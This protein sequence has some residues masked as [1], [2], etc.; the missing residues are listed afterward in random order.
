[1]EVSALHIL[2]YFSYLFITVVYAWRTI[3]YARMPMHLRWDLYPIPREADRKYGGSYFE[4][5]EW[6]KKR[7]RKGLVHDIIFMIKDYATFMQYFQQNRNYWFSLYPV[8]VGFYLVFLLHVLMLV[9]G[10]VLIAGIP[11]AADAGTGGQILYY[12]TLIVGGAG[13]IIGAIGCIALLIKRIT[14][15]DQ[16][17][18]TPPMYYFNYIF[19][20][21]MFL[22]GLIAWAFY[23]L[24]FATYR[25]FWESLLSLRALEVD[26]ATV[27]HI[28]FFS[29]FLIYMPFTRA[30]HY[31]TKLFTFFSIRWDDEP[32]IN[33]A[34]FGPRIGKLLDQRVSWSAPHIQ[35]GKKW[36]EVVTEKDNR[37]EQQGD[38]EN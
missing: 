6:W 21:L 9:G 37:G 2:T 8:H 38:K 19:F 22:S 7:R 1:M 11:V 27:V 18:F 16:R 17:M 20:F 29:L 33:G 10:I 36:S 3:K 35:T 32:N 31:I 24:S 13:F 15:K 30:M 23:D 4:E 25:H 12:L 28:V 26:A 34:T 14:D 5:I